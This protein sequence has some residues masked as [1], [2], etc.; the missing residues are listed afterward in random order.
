MTDGERATAQ[1]KFACPACGAEAHWTPAKQ[2]LVCAFCGTESPATLQTRGADTVVVEHD[3][4]SALRE[5]P[6]SKRGWKAAK[7]S[8]QCRSCQAI[9]VFDPERVGQ[10]CE[11]CGAAELV[12]YEQI[13]DAF[14]P[15]SLLPF[16]VSE[17]QA[18]DLI[19]AWYGRPLL[20]QRRESVVPS[21][22]IG[23]TRA[24][25]SE[26]RAIPSRSARFS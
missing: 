24:Q 2:A 1:Q 22:R 12:P 6:D 8:V 14:S 15:E 19:R 23:N 25:S 13:K 18:C 9:S 17:S 7:V 20:S 5:I 11:F 16:T 3:L 10:R 4:A 26:L 21:Q